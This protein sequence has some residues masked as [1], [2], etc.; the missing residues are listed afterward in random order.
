MRKRLTFAVLFIFL[1]CMTTVCCNASADEYVKVGLRYDSAVTTAEISSSAGLRL[2]TAGEDSI[3]AEK[4]NPLDGYGD[5]YLKLR[6]GKVEV[7]TH[8]GKSITT[9]TGDGTECLISADY[10]RSN[11]YV[12]FDE[13]VYRG[14]IIPYIN[15]NGGLN[16]IN[17][18]DVEDYVKGVLDKEM[19]HSSNLEALKAQAVSARSFAAAHEGLHA[20]Q[21]FDVCT[22]DHCQCYSGVAGEYASIVRAVESTRGEILYYEGEP[23]PGYYCA[24]SGGCTENSE[25]V[26]SESLGYLRSV[27]DPYSPEYKW[28]VSMKQ[29]EL[30]DLLASRNIGTIT[31]VTINGLNE[32]GSVQAVTFTGTNGSYHAVKDEVRFLPGMKSNFF[33]IDSSKGRVEK[34]GDSTTVYLDKAS[35]ELKIKGKGF[36][37]GIGMSQQGAQEMGKRG[38]TYREILE[39]YFTDIEVR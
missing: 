17:Y 30:T 15:E 22:G 20:S 8:S 1:V 3:T 27:E 9:L 29:S 10:F 21:G 31:A 12:C 36:G 34:N 6:D 19:N 18:V 13:T 14:G 37:H 39:F 23:V 5:I 25:D 4:T 32:S 11:A 28:S 35:D 26:W 38:F 33:T 7:T 2:C 24:N 16:I